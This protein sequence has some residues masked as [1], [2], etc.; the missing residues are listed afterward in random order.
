MIR[1][2]T[3]VSTSGPGTLAPFAP[4]DGL[5]ELTRGMA[6]GEDAAFLRFHHEWFPRLHRYAFTL[7]GGD[8]AR[9]ADIAQETCV[10][11]ARHAREFVDET[12]F[13][14]WLARIARSAAADLGRK[15]SRY[16][17][18]LD[19]F[20]LLRDEPATSGD[21]AEETLAEA[22]EQALRDAD[23]A[24]AEVLRA[25]YGERLSGREIARRLGLSEEAVESRLARARRALRAA[26][27]ERL[28]HEDA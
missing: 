25:K 27:G 5:R 28:K 20:A 21:E 8:A 1:S 23:P 22:L 24:H 7:A 18:L 11:V 15:R 12:I 14:R 6:R 16:A 19:R 10:R 13:W 26:V 4:A 2:P 17:R 9:A 3:F